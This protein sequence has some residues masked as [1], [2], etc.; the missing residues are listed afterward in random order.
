MRHKAR[1]RNHNKNNKVEP[2]ANSRIIM[3]ID[4][5]RKRET[6]TTIL[7]IVPSVYFVRKGKYIFCFVKDEP[8]DL[9]FQRICQVLKMLVLWLRLP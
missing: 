8:F 2:R 5:E 6:E 9:H 1:G 3:S 4:G 7:C